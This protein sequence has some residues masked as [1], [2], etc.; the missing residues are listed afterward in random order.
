MINNRPNNSASYPFGFKDKVKPFYSSKKGMSSA[1]IDN[2][3]SQKKEPNWMLNFRKKAYSLFISKKLPVWGPDL[4]KL[5]FK[6]IFYYLKPLPKKENSWEKIP[7]NIKNTFDKLGIPEAERKYLAGVETQYDSEVIYGNLK[8]ELTKKGVIF[9]D[10]DS[11]LKKYPELFKQHFSKIVSP[12]DNK[13]ASLNS[14]F[15]SGGTFIYIPKNVKVDLPL[16]AYFRINSEKLGQFERTLIIADSGSF[17]HY[18]EGCTAPSFTSSSLHSAV[19]EII[20]KNNARVRYTTIQNWSNNV[21][22]LVTKRAFVDE[23]GVMEWVDGNIGSKITMKY[24]SCYLLGR[25]AYGSVLSLAMAG[26][27]QIQDTGAKIIH[28]APETSSQIIAKSIG[29][30]GGR[31]S[32]RGLVHVTKKATK[33]K[34]KLNCDTLLIDSFSRSDTYPLLKIDNQSSSIEHEATVSKIGDEQLFY[35]L[36][37]GLDKNE[38]SQIIVNGFLEPIAKELP[39]EYAVELNRLINLEMT[40]SLG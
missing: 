25:K 17:V 20:V 27:A 19:V 22:N 28:L 18:I 37:R 6:D 21:Y 33:S 13:F 39:M 5:N 26:K 38:S 9:T 3:S 4:T 29:K 36:N 34:V 16:Q 7:E 23:E 8:N 15:W 11:A 14:A 32:F 10:T 35:L 40:G 1:I 24:P 12:Y 30:D 2:L 31:T